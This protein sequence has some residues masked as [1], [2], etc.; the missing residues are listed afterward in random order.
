[1]STGIVSVLGLIV[2][3][4]AGLVQLA[5]LEPDQRAWLLR[6]CK[7]WGFWAFLVAGFCNGAFGIFLFAI[8]PK[9]IDRWSVIFLLLF[10]FNCRLTAGMAMDTLLEKRRAK[11][12]ETNLDG[13]GSKGS[14]P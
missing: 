11:A 4:F 10:L 3:V 2:A 8:S 14:G 9:P 12:G 13:L 6:W 1:M 7:S 5:K